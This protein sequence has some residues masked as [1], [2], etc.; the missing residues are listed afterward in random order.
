MRKTKYLLEAIQASQKQITYCAVDLAKDSLTTSLSPLV[1]A[2]PSIKFVGLWGT[3]DDSLEW[4]KIN[5]KGRKIYFWLGLGLLILG[6]CCCY[7][8]FTTI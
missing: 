5:V 6:I 4:G 2:F 8:R 1:K 3:Y 7:F